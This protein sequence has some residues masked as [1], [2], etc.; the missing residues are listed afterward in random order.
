MKLIIYRKISYKTNY[1]ICWGIIAKTLTMTKREQRKL[2]VVERKRMRI[3]LERMKT[4]GNGP[5]ILMKFEI[6]NEMKGKD[7]VWKIKY[8]KLKWLGH[9]I[10]AGE[11]SMVFSVL[12]PRQANDQDQ[13]AC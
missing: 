7:I 3:V 9:M 1:A 12:G 8:Q 13:C 10:R 11:S 6:Q 2:I 4:A 5:Y